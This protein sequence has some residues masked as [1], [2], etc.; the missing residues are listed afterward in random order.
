MNAIILKGAALC[1][2]PLP[3][4]GPRAKTIAHPCLTRLLT[5][6]VRDR[7][8]SKQSTHTSTMEAQVESLLTSKENENTRIFYSHHRFDL[9]HARAVTIMTIIRWQETSFRFLKRHISACIAYVCISRSFPNV[10]DRHSFLIVTR[11]SYST[12]TVL[13]FCRGRSWLNAQIP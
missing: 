9:P 8:Y 2:P 5:V 4:S 3:Q 6:S 10:W 11:R 13:L 7:K 1:Q 12:P